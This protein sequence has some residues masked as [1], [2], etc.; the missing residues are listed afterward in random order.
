MRAAG[1]RQHHRRDR[2]R[3]T[4]GEADG[5]EIPAGAN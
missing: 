2:E 3:D 4:D 1:R 5:E